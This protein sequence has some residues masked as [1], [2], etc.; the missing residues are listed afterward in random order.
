[1][2]ETYIIQLFIRSFVRSLDRL[3]ACSFVGLL[4]SSSVRPFFH[5]YVIALLLLFDFS[6]I[7]EQLLRKET[8]LRKKMI[9]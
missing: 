9:S 1:M 6:W 7:I 2:L 5:S 4:V 8:P 3:F